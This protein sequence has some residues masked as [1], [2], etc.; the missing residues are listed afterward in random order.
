[1]AS[2]K[3]AMLV[4]L[5]TFLSASL[6]RKP[7]RVILLRYIRF[8]C[9]ARLSRAPK[10]SGRGSPGKKL[11]FW[12]DRN[13]GARNRNG[14]IAKQAS[15]APGAA[16]SPEAVPRQRAE[17]KRD[18]TDHHFAGR[19]RRGNAVLRSHRRSVST[20][21]EVG[22]GFPERQLQMRGEEIRKRAG[23]LN[24]D[25]EITPGTPASDNQPDPTPASKI[26]KSTAKSTAERWGNTPDGLAAAAR[27]S[28]ISGADA[29]LIR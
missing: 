18:R 27:K 5:A 6:P 8:S 2:E 14:A 1:M 29:D 28:M 12:G 3:I 9:S 24:Q 19:S 22:A 16:K 4:E 13:G 23:I 17:Q 15:Q 10:A 21:L 11:L 7:I 26:T 20:V 25:H